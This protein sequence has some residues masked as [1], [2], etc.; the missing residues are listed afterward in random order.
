MRGEIF[1]QCYNVSNITYSSSPYTGT[2][3]TGLGDDQYSGVI[4]IG[5]S[6]CFYGGMYNYLLIG[7]NGIVC[8]DTTLAGGSCHNN[9][10]FIPSLTSAMN[11][12]MF[13]SVDLLPSSGG[14]I[15]YALNGTSPNRAFVVSIDSLACYGHP[16]I[17][18]SSQVILFES[19]NE[20]EVHI[21]DKPSCSTFDV[22]TEGI[23]NSLGTF[24]AVVPGRNGTT[25]TATNDAWRFTPTCNVCSGIGI[26]EITGNKNTI[27][28]SPN[29]ATNQLS[30]DNGKLKINCIEIFNTLGEKVYSNAETSHST[31]ET[32]NV[33]PLS[34]GIYFVRVKTVSGISVAKFVKE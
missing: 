22:V 18:I 19:T 30:I 11:A 34:S 3:V 28:L 9:T 21:L 7:S 6:F 31:A 29:P 1:S 5:F 32:I 13:P 33:S 20:I 2:W 26:N 27:S 8:F 12:I 17:R 4:P 25:W 10:P 15:K 24:A 16:N 23:Q 14:L